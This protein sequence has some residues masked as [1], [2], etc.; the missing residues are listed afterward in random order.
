MYNV[1][2]FTPRIVERTLAGVSTYKSVSDYLANRKIKLIGDKPAVKC[3]R[4]NQ[5]FSSHEAV[6]TTCVRLE[7]K[8]DYNINRSQLLAEDTAGSN[9]WTWI[10]HRH[11]NVLVE[12]P[13]GHGLVNIAQIQTELGDPVNLTVKDGEIHIRYNWS[14]FG[15]E[16]INPDNRGLLPLERSNNRYLAR[17]KHYADHKL[18]SH[19]LRKPKTLQER[20]M[21]EAHALDEHSPAIRGRRKAKSLPNAWD[22]RPAHRERCWKVKKVKK[23]W[24]INF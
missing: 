20:K 16:S 10:N 5:S 21:A 14:R 22:D 4:C 3:F 13:E 2:P 17:F 23:Q 24:M 6:N 11:K 19:W 8:T 15:S 9:T 18:F 1:T 12:R 7:Y